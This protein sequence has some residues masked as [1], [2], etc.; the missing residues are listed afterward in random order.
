MVCVSDISTVQIGTYK[1]SNFA[2]QVQPLMHSHTIQS[3]FFCTSQTKTGMREGSEMIRGMDKELFM[4][5]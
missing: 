2:T 3:F 1:Y 5:R 4:Q